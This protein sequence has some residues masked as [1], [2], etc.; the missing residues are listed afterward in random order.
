MSDDA[1]YTKRLVAEQRIVQ[2]EAENQRLREA[3]EKATLCIDTRYG[4][5]GSNHIDH[6]LLVELRRALQESGDE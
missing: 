2:L 3:L 1:I 6:D 4:E 5:S